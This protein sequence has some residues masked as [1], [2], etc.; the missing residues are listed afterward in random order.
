ME[1]ATWAA[2]GGRGPSWP[3]WTASAWRERTESGLKRRSARSDGA[4][5]GPTTAKSQKTGPLII[6]VHNQKVILESCSYG[7]VGKTRPGERICVVGV[8]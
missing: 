3:G 4:A 2:A 5:A 8:Q 1:A 7:R 6:L